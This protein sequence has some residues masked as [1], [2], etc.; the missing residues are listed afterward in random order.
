VIVRTLKV[1]ESHPQISG[2]I[3]VA[4]TDENSA[5][6][7][8]LAGYALKKCLAV[9]PGG[10]TRQCSVLLGLKA[11]ESCLAGGD[12]RTVLAGAT[13]GI[14][15]NS[16]SAATQD[17]G[18]TGSVVLVHD[19]AR[20]FVT[21]DII[22]RVIA[23]V[24]LHQACGAAVAVKDTIKEADES[25]LVCKTLD[26][27]VLWAM[28]T[29]QGATYRLLRDAY[30][31]A[32]LNNWQVTDDLAVLERA[33]RP[34][35]IVAGAGQNIKLTTPED[36]LLAEQLAR[37]ADAAGTNGTNGTNGANPAP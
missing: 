33:G 17:S 30:D 1:L 15:V 11:L 14:T 32:V 27:K 7:R 29:P 6:S 19:G 8:L 26:R 16:S 37:L 21:P 35:Y 34:V 5:M 20:C 12:T 4:A 2:Y 10:P 3:V 22:D 9:T 13:A 36:Q 23:G 18:W 28:Q 31:L 25:G 24:R